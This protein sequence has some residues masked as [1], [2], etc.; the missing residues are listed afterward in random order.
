[1][2]TNKIIKLSVLASSVL[3]AQQIYAL[4]ALSDQSLRTVSG[5]DGISLSYETDRVTID[6]LNWKDNTNFSNGTSGNLN[7]SLN[8]IE[9]SK[10]DNNKIGGKVKLDVGTNANKTGMRIEAVVNPA[11]IHIAKVAVCGDGTRGADCT[12][13]NTLGALTLQNRAP[14]NFVL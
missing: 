9:V 7:L 6:Q 3:L 11:N 4:E 13:Q 10:I 1:M 8:N 12:S 5:Q 14:M 2:S